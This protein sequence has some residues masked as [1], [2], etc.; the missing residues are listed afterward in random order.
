MIINQCGSPLGNW[1]IHCDFKQMEKIRKMFKA[2]MDT[3]R[4]DTDREI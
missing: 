2:E 4:T 3:T 1:E